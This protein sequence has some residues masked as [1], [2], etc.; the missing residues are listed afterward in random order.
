MT[1]IPGV[2][3]G[4]GRI[5]LSARHFKDG[6]R[7]LSWSWE[8]ESS[9]ILSES[10]HLLERMD[11]HVGGIK[12]WIYNED[13]IDA[14]LTFFLMA[15]EDQKNPEFR[16][17]FGLNYSG[18]RAAWID[19][20][21][22]AKNP[23]FAG[24]AKPINTMK[25]VAPTGRRGGRVWLDLVQ[26]VQKAAR[27]RTADYQLP[28]LNR[29]RGGGSKKYLYLRADRLRPRSILPH[30][31]QELKK[32]DFEKIA[33][34]A[35]DWLIGTEPD[36][37]KEDVTARYKSQ[38][39]LFERADQTYENLKI[40]AKNKEIT[41]EPLFSFHDDRALEERTFRHVHNAVLLPLVLAYHT[42]PG[43]GKDVNNPYYQNANVRKRIL[44]LLNYLHDQGWA[45]GS[46]LGSLDHGSL[47]MCGYAHAVFLM[48]EE[49]AQAGILERELS[50]LKW[51]SRFGE[52]YE[53]LGKEGIN[54]DD[55]RTVQIYRL[56]YILCQ[57]SRPEKLEMMRDWMR[58][59]ESGLE[60]RSGWQDMLKPDG[61][62]YHHKGIYLR[63]YVQNALHLSSLVAYFLRGTP[64]ARSQ[65][66][67]ENLKRALLSARIMCNRYDAPLSLRGRWPF[68]QRKLE[69]GYPVHNP[70][71]AELF[72]AYA[73]LALSFEP[74]D[75]ELVSAFMR[76]YDPTDPGIKRTM[77]RSRIFIQFLT[78]LGATRVIHEL[79][80]RGIIEE[81]APNGHWTFPY[82][83]LAIHRRG[84]WMVA[85]KGH[86]KYVWDFETSGKRK[87]QNL[88]GRYL[89]H[90]TM[91]IHSRGS[92]VNSHDSGYASPGW[93]WS[94]LPGSTAI[95]LPHTALAETSSHRNFNDQVTV[96]GVSLDGR[97]GLFAMRLNDTVYG[98]GLGAEKSFF[99]FDKNI[100]C[101]GSGIR[102]QESAHSTETILFQNYLAEKTLSTWVNDSKEGITRIPFR[103]SG[104][105]GKQFWILD[106]AG[107]GY[108]IPDAENLHL[109]RVIQK[110]Q[111]FGIDLGGSGN[112][113]L[114]WIDHGIAP[115]DEG[116]EYAVLVGSSPEATR[117]F[118]ADPEY[119][120]WRKDSGAHIVHSRS[121]GITGYALFEKNLSLERGV[122]QKSDSPCFAMVSTRPGG[123]V[124]SVADPDYGWSW[125]GSD[126]H[127]FKSVV[128]AQQSRPRRLQFWLRGR[129]RLGKTSEGTA[130]ADYP[131]GNQTLLKVSCIDGKSTEVSLERISGNN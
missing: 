126:P 95:R 125:T 115:R 88:L 47:Y 59:S 93:D 41:G 56:Y 83:G 63:G 94:R 81:P 6:G 105:K 118:A 86:S 48:R 101:L 98:T 100:I 91:W 34:R 87:G 92:P 122:I 120:V 73:Y 103:V 64:F 108:V 76:L 78:T 53:K 127:S 3:S 71:L 106:S 22:D 14:K 70:L 8:T 74:V 31:V 77:N 10:K 49:L 44:T 116:Y 99:F 68:P 36:F 9:L 20:E 32:S 84:E 60:I 7:S 38:L 18:W 128:L 54:T 112:F 113:E 55:L 29:R 114:A 85:V 107:N 82:G 43:S 104:K 28:F 5:S 124:L 57:D 97:N 23:S 45:A 4:G 72:P 1:S 80:R 13:P 111:K 17:E 66:A 123:L 15:A 35:E 79:A 24:P 109:R 37:S 102:S 58:W 19:L 129:W 40:L 69:D 117:N 26:F 61:S 51:Y 52:V 46:A 50:T 90:G 121:L 25:I 75:R 11:R 16:F 110:T 2:P 33:R 89:S 27:D 130:T 42:A 62:G 21:E 96:G 67:R 131:G 30:A 39:E 65:K 12:V 119:E